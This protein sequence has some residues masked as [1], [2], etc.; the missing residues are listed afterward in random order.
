MGVT[1]VVT[2]FVDALPFNAS[3]EFGVNLGGYA[4]S[5]GLFDILVVSWCVAW[6]AI[7]SDGCGS[8]CKSESGLGFTLS[9]N[10]TGI[11]SI[12]SVN[13]GGCESVS[14]TLTK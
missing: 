1:E 8:E 12:V 4:G 5:V 13:A 11:A 10:A 2:S 6:D 3:F 7:V 9:E 14:D